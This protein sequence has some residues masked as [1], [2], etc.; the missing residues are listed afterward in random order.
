[1]TSTSQQIILHCLPNCMPRSG[2]ARTQDDK[3]LN[4]SSVRATALSVW[5]SLKKWPGP[6]L[7]DLGYSIF[8][9]YCI[10][11]FEL[12]NRFLVCVVEWG[13]TVGEKKNFWRKSI[14]HSVRCMNVSVNL[15]SVMFQL[16]D[17]RQFLNLSE[18]HFSFPS[19]KWR[20]STYLIMT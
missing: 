7:Y 4:F 20:Y 18:P 10:A 6:H 9:W 19:V 2:T 14:G 12:K 8:L 15:S 1:M 17:F 3:L 5:R 11:Q 13:C 16:W